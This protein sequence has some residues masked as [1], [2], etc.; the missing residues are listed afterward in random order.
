[1]TPAPGR[2]R[3]RNAG[4]GRD[5]ARDEYGSASILVVA[6]AGAMVAILAATL[7]VGAV[8]LAKRRAGAVADLAALA[9]ADAAVGRIAGD[10]CERAALVA[11]ANDAGLEDC[12][13]E[14]LEATV[15]VGVSVPGGWRAEVR[16][17]AGPPGR[18]AGGMRPEG[19]GRGR[20]R[21]EGSVEQRLQV[22][23]ADGARPVGVRVC[24]RVFGFGS[25]GT[26][27]EVAFGTSR[28]GDL[29]S[30]P[31]VS[32]GEELGGDR[33]ALER[34]VGQLGGVR[35][36]RCR[37]HASIVLGALRSA[38]EHTLHACAEGERTAPD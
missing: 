20:T 16:A 15:T 19:F 17:R 33:L 38:R 9:A 14:G 37:C 18:S 30:G 25:C 22:S 32:G 34:S 21:P 8:H 5:G 13:M 35:R 3:Q 36:Q 11:E 24:R 10:P 2:A 29:E 6:L 23:V 1:M 27:I 12:A 26:H 4:C 7:T 31:R 28:R